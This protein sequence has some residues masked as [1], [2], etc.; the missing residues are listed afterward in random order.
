MY[1]PNNIYLLNSCC[2]KYM[3][4]VFR[5]RLTIWKLGHY[6]GPGSV[7]GPMRCPWYSFHRL[8]LS[9]G[10]DTGAP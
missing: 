6:R 3:N 2:T 10:K 4:N 9:L 8:F 1:W 7:V 5:G